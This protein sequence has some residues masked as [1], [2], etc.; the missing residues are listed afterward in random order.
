VP[1]D[2]DVQIKINRL[3]YMDEACRDLFQTW[4]KQREAEGQSIAVDYRRLRAAQRDTVAAMETVTDLG[5]SWHKAL[6]AKPP[7]G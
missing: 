6:P 3:T 1:H 5:H 2:V 4:I 7:P